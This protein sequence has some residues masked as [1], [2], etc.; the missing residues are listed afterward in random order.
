MHERKSFT[1]FEVIQNNL[2]LKLYI[3]YKEKLAYARLK[4]S[5]LKKDLKSIFLKSLYMQYF[6]V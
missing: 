2:R 3:N 1:K 6:S 4:T 5:K